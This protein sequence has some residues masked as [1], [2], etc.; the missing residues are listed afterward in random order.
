MFVEYLKNRSAPA[1]AAALGA[2][3]AF[4]QARC[5]VWLTGAALLLLLWLP[6]RGKAG[7]DVVDT[8]IDVL[9]AKCFAN[10][11]HRCTQGATCSSTALSL[12]G[13]CSRRLAVLNG[14]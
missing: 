14:I 7:A 11:G 12:P 9:I 5:C 4:L 13:A 3:R 1:A 2:C 10:E 6:Q 8:L